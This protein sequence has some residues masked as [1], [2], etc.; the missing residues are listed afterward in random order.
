MSHT[1]TGTQRKLT[2]IHRKK[3]EQFPAGILLPFPENSGVFLQYPVTF[4]HLSGGIRSFPEA[5]I[6]DLGS[7]VFD[8]S[9]G[10]RGGGGD[11]PSLRKFFT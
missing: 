4:P 11:R 6:I 8:I 2:G 5:G 9:G 7:K 1:L 3:S 10:F